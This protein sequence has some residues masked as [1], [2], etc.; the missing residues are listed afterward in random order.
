VTGLKVNWRR[1][2]AFTSLSFITRNRADGL[3]SKEAAPLA[4]LRTLNGVGV[5]RRDASQTFLREF[6]LLIYRLHRN[7][8]DEKRTNSNANR[9]KF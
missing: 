6:R 2:T 5:R 1:F 3:S 4:V 8:G 9:A 7:S